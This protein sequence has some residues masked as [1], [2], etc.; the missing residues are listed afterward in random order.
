MP[1]TYGSS[2][3]RVR[4]MRSHD[5]RTLLEMLLRL[6]GDFRRRLKPLSV[7]VLQ[8]GVILYLSRH[9]NAKLT[10]TAASLGVR[11]STLTEVI[12]DLVVRRWVTNRPSPQDRRA[13]CLSL[14][15]RGKVIA[16]HITEQVRQVSTSDI[17]PTFPGP[18]Q[19]HDDPGPLTGEGLP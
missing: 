17:D 13:V 10:K 5:K 14:S 16:R 19:L 11:P 2:V 6:H 7:T 3:D 15:R 9:T 1:P 18:A 12:Q 4:K 8:A